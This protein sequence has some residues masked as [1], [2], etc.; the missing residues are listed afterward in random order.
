MLLGLYYAYEPLLFDVD[1]YTSSVNKAMVFL[2]LG[3]SFSTLQDTRKTHYKLASR[4]F[5]SPRW[6]RYFIIY[7]IVLIFLITGAGIFGLFFSG[8]DF[9]EQLAIGF[10]VM[11]ISLIGM[12]KAAVE[13]AENHQRK[14]SEAIP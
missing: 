8:N 4:I 12:L 10:I 11:G 1:S 6:S 7:L 9:L 2:G 5:G 14:P 13:M 3:I